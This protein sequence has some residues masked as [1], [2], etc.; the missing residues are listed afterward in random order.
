MSAK[1]MSK[2]NMYV[3]TTTQFLSFRLNAILFA[4][5]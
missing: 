3:A 5:V 2:T 1:N 4:V